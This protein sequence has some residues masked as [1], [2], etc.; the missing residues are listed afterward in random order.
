M[1]GRRFFLGIAL[2]ASVSVLAACNTGN[3]NAPSIRI[4]SKE[5]TEQ[6]ILGNLYEIL[7]D[8]LGFNADYRP[9]GGSS[10]NHQAL[11]NG[12][13]D[14][15]P[16][17]TGTALLVHLGQEFDPSM[18]ADDVYT[19]VK[20][21][22]AEQFNLVF[23]DPTNFNNTYVFVMPKPLASELDIQT[24]SDLSAKAGDLTF[25]TNQEFTERDDG[26]PGLKNAYGGFEFKDVF[27]LEIGLRYS[28]LAEGEID[29]GTGFGTDGQIIALD[30]LALDDDKNFWPPYPAAPVIRQEIL[31]AHPEVADALNQISTLLDADTMQSL[32]WEVDGNDREPD[33]VAREFLEQ[34]GL[35]GG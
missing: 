3:S 5:F 35:I 2:S 13:I 30:L 17:Y 33:E 21:A 15:Y 24:M 25:G 19:T 23:L 27:A 18:A 6:Y 1:I 7:L 26:L 20:D 4:G 34:N 12:E 29:V 32:N 31:D 16:E 22:Y 28:G 10:E 11:V 8:E 9:L 14:V